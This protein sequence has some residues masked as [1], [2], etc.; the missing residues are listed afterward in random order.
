[1]G[2]AMGGM[3]VGG[4][5]SNLEDS[6]AEAY[7]ANTPAAKCY[8]DH[9]ESYSTNEITIYWNSPL[10]YLLALTQGEVQ[11]DIPLVRG[12]VDADGHFLMNDVVMLQK[13]IVC[14]GE[15]NNWAVGD[16][17][18]DDQINTVDLSI[19]KQWMLA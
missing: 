17:N 11:T 13:W 9:A 1:V 3:L 2:K 18:E 12:D 14:G 15:I 7:L 8:V 16:L 6:A 5:N 10:T 19:M 4:V